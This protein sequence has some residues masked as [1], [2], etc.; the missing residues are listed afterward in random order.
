MILMNLIILPQHEG[1]LIHQGRCTRIQCSPANEKQRREG[2]FV[3]QETEGYCLHYPQCPELTVPCDLK[4]ECLRNTSHPV[5]SPKVQASCLS[6]PLLYI[7]VLPQA[8]RPMVS[9]RCSLQWA[10]RRGQNYHAQLSL[11]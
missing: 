11:Q 2:H 5:V 10:K 8:I 4:L 3:Q 1:Q 9:S 6:N 7:Y